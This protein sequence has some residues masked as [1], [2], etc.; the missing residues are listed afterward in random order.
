M[1]KGTLGHED[2]RSPACRHWDTLVVG[3]TREGFEANQATKLPAF[4]SPGVQPP[5]GDA[6][7]PKRI[8][9]DGY[10]RI[11]ERYAAWSGQDE[12]DPRG[13]NQIA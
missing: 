2:R 13:Y 11:A 9:A 12:D 6:V 10:D 1:G 7:D 3:M 8:V 5:Q 4:P